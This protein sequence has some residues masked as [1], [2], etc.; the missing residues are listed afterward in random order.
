[1]GMAEMLV[2]KEMAVVVVR[3]NYNA[4]IDSSTYKV[5]TKLR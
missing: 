4:E 3:M 5:Y 1:M 2:S